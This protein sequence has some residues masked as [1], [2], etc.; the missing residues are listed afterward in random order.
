MQKKSVTIA[1]VALEAGVS[2]A[3][4]SKVIRSAYGVSE[5]MRI[6]VQGAIDSLGY[7]PSVAARAY[8]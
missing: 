3:A 6:R 4:V 1:D 5:D 8:Q 7:R 2:R